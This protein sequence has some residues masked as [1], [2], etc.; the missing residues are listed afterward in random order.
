[1]KQM[2]YYSANEHTNDDDNDGDD[3]G[4]ERTAHIV[5]WISYLWRLWRTPT[6]TIHVILRITL[7][8]YCWHDGMFSLRHAIIQ[9]RL[10]SKAR[11]HQDRDNSSSRPISN[12][13]R[14]RQ[15]C[16]F[17]LSKICHSSGWKYLKLYKV[18]AT[19]Q[20]R[21]AQ[22][23]RDW[24]GILKSCSWFVVRMSWHFGGFK[25]KL[26]SSTIHSLSSTQLGF[27][28]MTSRS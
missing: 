17:D 15:D 21:W 10:L 19:V 5:N 25:Y 8:L 26:G 12:T 18:I 22:I 24:P 1:M 7:S 11:S 28:S 27:E 3:N 23:H 9:S 14:R 6:N 20:S 13:S 4:N 16:P 2:K